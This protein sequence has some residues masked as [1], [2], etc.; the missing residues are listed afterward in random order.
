M[1]NLITYL[2]LIVIINFVNAQDK[3]AIKYAKTIT[4]ADLNSNLSILASDEYEGRETGKR[5]QKM[6]AKYIADKF[7][8][9]GLEAPVNGSYYQKFELTES[10]IGALYFREGEDKKV[11]FE[12]FIYYSRSETSGEEYVK[13][14]MAGDD[15]ENAS[16]YAGKYMAYVTEKMGGLE[17]RIRIAK[18]AG[19]VGFVIVITNDDEF[20]SVLGRYG[21]Y[22][23]GAGLKLDTRDNESDKIIIADRG[24]VSWVFDKEFDE[25]KSGENTTIVF[26]ADYLDKSVGT[27]NVLGYLKGSE[28]PEELVVITAHYDHI[29]ITGE[30][31]NNGA[32]DDGSGTTSVLELAQAFTT[33]AAQGKGPKRSMLFMTVTGEEKGLLGSEYYTDNPVFP[34]EN[35]V[36]NLNIDMVGR[37]DDVH[38]ENPNY[39]YLIGTDRLSQELHELSEKVNTTYS[40][41]DLDYTYNDEDDP[42]R[43]YYRSDHYNFA[44]YNIPI[45]FYFNG[46]HEDYH[47]P[48]DTIEKI[49]FELMED[50]ARLIF[51]TAWEVANQDKRIIA[52]KL[53]GAIDKSDD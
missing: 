27:E 16:E 52:D 43:F 39:I 40:N 8:E 42:N 12:D 37:V 51:H 7:K 19:A 29:G 3:Q 18:E 49:N 1:R 53:E 28:K 10:A 5:G 15:D 38:L 25:I 30:D 35:T 24:L 45:I 26:N 47:Q 31:I 32:D 11:G 2:G 9:F 36:T 14:M 44:K 23:K 13:I 22:L 20:G 6:A 41:L 21:R 48:T 33:A 46:T 50:R 34:L 17:E 4:A